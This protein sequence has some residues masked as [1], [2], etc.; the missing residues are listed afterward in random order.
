MWAGNQVAW[1]AA[2]VLSGES[3]L[4]RLTR[5]RELSAAYCPCAAAALPP[6]VRM[7]SPSSGAE[8]CRV[9]ARA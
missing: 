5:L 8:D 7:G 4:N 2:H 6:D 3:R 9:A 1:N